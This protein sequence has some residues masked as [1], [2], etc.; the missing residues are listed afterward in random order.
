MKLRRRMLSFWVQVQAC[1]LPLVL[2]IQEKGFKN[3][4]A[5]LLQNIILQICIPGGFTPIR[6]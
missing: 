2:L 5:I 4:S 1:L 3:I 6:L